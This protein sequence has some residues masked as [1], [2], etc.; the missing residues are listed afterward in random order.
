M[1]VVAGTLAY[2]LFANHVGVY[3]LWLLL[4]PALL[5][6]I[7]LEERALR[8]RFGPAWEEYARRVPRFVPRSRRDGAA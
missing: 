6:V 5:L 3:V 7:R 4:F 8:E 1:E 2:A